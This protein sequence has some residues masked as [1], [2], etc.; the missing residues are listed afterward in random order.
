MGP[1]DLQIKHNTIASYAGTVT[2][3]TTLV[4][5]YGIP[6]EGALFPLTHFVL[7][8]NIFAARA[9]PMMLSAAA[10]LDTLMPGY[11]WTNNV[12]AGPWPT[13]GGWTAAMMP[14]GNGNAYPTSLANV[15]Y[16]NVAV[17]DYSL[18][19]ISPYKG[20]GS[21]GTDIGVDWNQFNT[22]NS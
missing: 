10:N 20:A 6:D 14:Q 18:S 15:G 21:D 5:S 4:F 3:G 13:S 19:S 2:R 16:V 1:S 8:D 17:G 9:Y 12:F 22:A 7:Q 11:I